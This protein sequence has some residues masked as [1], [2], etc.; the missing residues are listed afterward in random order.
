MAERGLLE[1]EDERMR[2]EERK[3]TDL[4]YKRSRERTEWGMR[5]FGK[6]GYRFL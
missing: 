1:D 3:G 4:Y 5:K 6:P 2:R